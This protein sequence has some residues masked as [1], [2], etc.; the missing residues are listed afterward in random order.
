METEECDCVFHEIAR[1]MSE[2]ETGP[3][4]ECFDWAFAS[5]VDNA[6]RDTLKAMFNEFEGGRRDLNLV[7]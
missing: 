1:C 2:F 7:S 3:P 4:Q 5:Y 6:A